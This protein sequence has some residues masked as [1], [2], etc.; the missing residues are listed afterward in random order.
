MLAQPLLE[1]AAAL[2]AA[3]VRQ[4]P[5][6]LRSGPSTVSA[7]DVDYVAAVP[8]LAAGVQAGAVVAPPVRAR[9]PPHQAPADQP[10]ERL[11]DQGLAAGL[12]QAVGEPVGQQP[13]RSLRCHAQARQLRELRLRCRRHLVLLPAGQ[14]LPQPRHRPQCHPQTKIS[15][16]AHPLLLRLS[17][18]HSLRPTT[19]PSPGSALSCLFIDRG[20][21]RLFPAE[22]A[23]LRHRQPGPD[24][25]GLAPDGLVL[26]R[27]RALRPTALRP[28]AFAGK[29]TRELRR[30]DGSNQVRVISVKGCRSVGLC[31]CSPPDLL[32]LA[33]LHCFPGP[34]SLT[35]PCRIVGV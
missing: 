11:S 31:G 32:N 23:A 4:F 28:T 16:Q 27:A 7:P 21:L 8:A 3:Q 10:P 35:R 22:R 18:T 20:L 13:R 17:T 29:A 9:G 12:L 25:A 26:A 19:G 33:D 34:W 2:F 24:S 14:P 1:D 15:R 6:D 30:N 5:V